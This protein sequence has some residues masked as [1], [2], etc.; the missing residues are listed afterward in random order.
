MVLPHNA[1]ARHETWPSTSFI[2]SVPDEQRQELLRLGTVTSYPRG[3]AILNQGTPGDSVLFLLSG[4][5]KIFL[6]TS[7]GEVLLALRS[8]GAVIGEM[9]FVTREPRSARVVAATRVTARVVVGRDFRAFLERW[10]PVREQLTAAVVRKLQWSNDRRAEFRLYT[11]TG[12]L[13]IVLSDAAEAVGGT[14]GG[15]IALGPELT[16]SDLAE[17][18]SI[19]TSAVEKALREWELAGL[20]VRRRQVLVVTDPSA[21]RTLAE[22]EHRN[23]YREG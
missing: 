9:A 15:G 18:A 4:V 19:S 12:R 3:Q 20:V 14:V 8:R 7:E 6:H 11:T 16:Q 21:L 23:P 13:A 17:L 5:V 1:A 10:T 22:K 2:A